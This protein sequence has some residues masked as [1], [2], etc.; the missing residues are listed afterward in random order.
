MKYVQHWQRQIGRNFAKILIFSWL[1]IFILW[2]FFIFGQ[3]RAREFIKDA[4][5][6]LEK[7]QMLGSQGLTVERIIS[8]QRAI[9][10]LGR[11]TG[12]NPFDAGTHFALAES[13]N[14]KIS[15][16]EHWVKAL[17]LE[18]LDLVRRGRDI[19]LIELARHNY[20][21]ALKLNPTNAIYHQR[22][23]SVYEKLSNDDQA[24]KELKKAVMLDPQNV[25]IHLYLTQYYLSRNKQNEFNYHLGR[26]V[27]L[28]KRALTG[29]G[30][31]ERLGNMVSEYLASIK[32]EELIKD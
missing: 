1:S 32:R 30:P 16:D 6:H 7:A 31:M 29:G 25:S 11:A 22:L 2:L 9:R 15:L 17:D 27:E 8:Y 5:A 26:V 14:S 10:L 23:A 21:E 20:I 28:Y 18:S 4:Q 3:L 24:E 12:A 13:I 19:S